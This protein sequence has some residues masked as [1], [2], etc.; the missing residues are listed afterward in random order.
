MDE[1]EARLAQL[2]EDRHQINVSIHAVSKELAQAKSDLN[3][4]RAPEYVAEYV[5][6]SPKKAKTS[7]KQATTSAKQATTSAKKPTP[8]QEPAALG[9]MRIGSAVARGSDRGT[10]I[11]TTGAGL[12]CII[13]TTRQEKGKQAV[14]DRNRE[15]TDA[16]SWQPRSDS[17]KDMSE[18]YGKC[19]DD[20]FAIRPAAQEY[21]KT[22]LAG[23]SAE[24]TTTTIEHMLGFMHVIIA[25]FKSW[26]GESNNVTPKHVLLCVFC[27]E[28]I[29]KSQFVNSECIDEFIA[30][31]KSAQQALY[32]RYGE[33]AINAE[34]CKTIKT[35][36]LRGEP[37]RE[38]AMARLKKTGTWVEPPPKAKTA[39]NPVG[40]IRH[41][42]MLQS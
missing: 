39:K 20:P 3:A 7:A 25:A 6:A 32:A 16:H 26:K 41:P 5:A 13:Y 27:A 9:S 42:L 28:D 10:I 24:E 11:A 14:L 35:E 12:H 8:A 4:S 36:L 15:W 30:S 23:R 37:F 29:D 17:V 31:A 21:L 1:L 18:F 19:E 22:I 38:T 40:T 34:L 2:K 33:S